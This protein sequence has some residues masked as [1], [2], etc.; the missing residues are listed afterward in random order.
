MYIISDESRAFLNRQ[1]SNVATRDTL[2]SLTI[3]KAIVDKITF[4]ISST[5]SESENSAEHFR[6]A[7]RGEANFLS[8]L[9]PMDMGDIRNYTNAWGGLHVKPTTSQVGIYNPDHPLVG[10]SAMGYAFSNEELCLLSTREAF[11]L[12]FGY[13]GVLKCR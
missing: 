2:H 3:S 6:K 12:Y 13:M 9:I 5:F 7:V 11:V 8:N 10:W 1:L 4:P